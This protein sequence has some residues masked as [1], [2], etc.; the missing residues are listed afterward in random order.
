MKNLI[1]LN[2][3]L[4]KHPLGLGTVWQL[5]GGVCVTV[6]LHTHTIMHY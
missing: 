4:K 1:S 5:T 6:E 3:F 2:I